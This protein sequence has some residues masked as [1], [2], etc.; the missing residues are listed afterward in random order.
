M[1]RHQLIKK[2]N[3]LECEVE[4]LNKKIIAKNNHI[5]E[6]KLGFKESKQRVK[7]FR[8]ELSKHDKNYISSMEIPEE[9]DVIFSNGTAY[10]VN[11]DNKMTNLLTNSTES[12]FI[13]EWWKYCE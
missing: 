6:Y 12:V 5:N 9:G 11:H 3:D 2:V 1:N 8:L 4:M 10:L 7:E 13:L